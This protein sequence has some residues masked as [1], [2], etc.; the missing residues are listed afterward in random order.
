MK[1]CEEKYLYVHLFLLKTK[2]CFIKMFLTCRFTKKSR[3]TCTKDKK[4]EC[5][6]D[7]PIRVFLNA[8]GPA[9]FLERLVLLQTASVINLII[10]NVCNVN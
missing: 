1:K 9:T 6:P 7:K 2:Q 3:P 5:Y 8:C 10:T 4:T